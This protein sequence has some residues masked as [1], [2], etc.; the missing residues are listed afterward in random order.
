MSRKNS[1]S[2][3][4]HYQND[5]KQ[6]SPLIFLINKTKIIKTKNSKLNDMTNRVKIRGK[7]GNS[8]GEQSD[9]V[10]NKTL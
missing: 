1:S 2:M 6:I 7:R 4:K 9:Q 10:E 8:I 3:K 5:I